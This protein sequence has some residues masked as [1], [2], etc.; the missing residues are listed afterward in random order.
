[1][2]D[3][4]WKPDWQSELDAA[5]QTAT[6][7]PAGIFTLDGEIIWLN[8]GMRLLLGMDQE[9][10]DPLAWLI[11]PSFEQLRELATNEG[12][13][14]DGLLTAGD[15]QLLSRSVR[16]SVYRKRDR[17]LVV[18]EF[19]A[20]QLDHLNRQMSQLNQEISNLQRELLKER[21][22]LQET[23]KELSV[24][25]AK[26]RRLFEG[27][28]LGIF[29]SSEDGRLLKAN[30]AF[31][32]TFGYASPDELMQ[33]VSNL[34]QDLYDDPDRFASSARQA[35]DEDRAVRVEERF[36][37]RDGSSFLA[38]LR[39]WAVRGDDQL[40][41]Y[42]EGFVEDIE[43]QKRSEAALVQ[44]RKMES[45]AVLAGGIAHEFNNALASLVGYIDLLQLSFP[46]ETTAAGYC[47]SMHTCSQRMV[48]LARRLLA[49][50]KGGKYQ[51]R[52]Q[53][54][55]KLVEDTL[56]ET[57]TTASAGI[58]WDTRI[59]P[60]TRP[61]MADA[62]QLKMVISILLENAIEALEPMDKTG[63]VA[64]TLAETHLDAEALPH[65]SMRP[66]DYIR[67]RVADDGVGMPS[68]V[69]ERIFEPFYT[70]KFQGRGMGMAAAYGI[71]KNHD[72]WIFVDSTP[73]EGTQVQIL[74]PVASESV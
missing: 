5:V 18:S 25:E 47:N 24:S 68:D 58:G 73:D 61:V 37:R 71:V 15:G 67:L 45:V 50:A 41:V 23:L 56:A 32:E 43:E 13:A 7:L 64:V 12:L 46:N 52:L 2:P 14:F 28:V 9:N 40:P 55:S 1:M 31:A 65:A 4:P 20:L 53:S 66:G 17:L 6:A 8:Q 29:Q 74:M 21:N 39:K 27:A 38:N 63:R 34:A 11:N 33:S 42:L 59:A 60:R 10:T 3:T 70:T 54:M 72:G 30:P 22:S 48:D 69:R 62:T 49:Y 26:Y 44:A 16:A 57:R 35:I 51:P 19:E 36:R